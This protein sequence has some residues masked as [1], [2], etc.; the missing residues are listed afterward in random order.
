MPLPVTTRAA[1]AGRR[2]GQGGT[3]PY[4]AP[5]RI[6]EATNTAIAPQEAKAQAVKRDAGGLGKVKDARERLE[7][8]YHCNS[9]RN[10]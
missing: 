8:G 3:Q 5:D 10:S 2:E 9:V 1:C 4:S 6:T 7:L